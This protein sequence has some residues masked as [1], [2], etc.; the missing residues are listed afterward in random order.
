MG[1]HASRLKSQSFTGR[2]TALWFSRV[3]RFCWEFTWPS[4][5]RSPENLKNEFMILLSHRNEKKTEK[6]GMGIIYPFLP[7]SF[8]LSSIFCYNHLSFLISLHFFLTSVHLSSR[9]SF[10]SS[11]IPSFLPL[12][13]S[14][15]YYTFSS[16]NRE[17][18]KLELWEQ[19]LKS[20]DLQNG[21]FIFG[22]FETINQVGQTNNSQNH[23]NFARHWSSTS[24]TKSSQLQP[25]PPLLTWPGPAASLYSCAELSWKCVLHVQS[26]NRRS[27]CTYIDG[28]IASP[29]SG[30]KIK[31]IGHALLG[32]LDEH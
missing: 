13:C 24:I 2:S 10:L 9:P 12:L 6:G 4:L 7:F 18:F 32:A 25:L 16:S 23:S 5:N 26:G 1:I 22:R 11:S 20:R 29:L 27:L 31:L 8:G 14:R 17:K 15:L 3:F 28:I 21:M 19:K 30:A